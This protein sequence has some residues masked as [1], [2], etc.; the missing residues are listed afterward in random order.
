MREVSFASDVVGAGVDWEAVTGFLDLG[1]ILI[2]RR[3]QRKFRHMKRLI[4]QGHWPV[5]G[6]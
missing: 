4:D 2:L 6:W 5:S 1:S 3:L